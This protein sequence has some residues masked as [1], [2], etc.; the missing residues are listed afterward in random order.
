MKIQ[1]ESLKALA[2][3]IGMNWPWYR[4]TFRCWAMV[5]AKV[6]SKGLH[7]QTQPPKAAV[8]Q[9]ATP[10]REG[11]ESPRIVSTPYKPRGTY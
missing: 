9:R 6:G 2:V 7:C 5:E 1:T 3:H 8:Y 11:L 4:S 10:S